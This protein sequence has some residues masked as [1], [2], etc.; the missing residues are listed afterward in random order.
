MID[1]HNP[2]DTRYNFSLYFDVIPEQNQEGQLV[3]D[4]MQLLNK[5]VEELVSQI[6]LG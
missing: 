6:G 5:K 4:K 2:K 1:D 3:E